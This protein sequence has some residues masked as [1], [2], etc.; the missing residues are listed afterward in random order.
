[1]RLSVSNLM[2]TAMWAYV[3]AH[4]AD[5]PARLFLHFLHVLLTFDGI[6]SGL[7]GLTFNKS[8]SCEGR[9]RTDFDAFLALAALLIH[10]LFR[11]LQ[12]GIG[13]NGGKTNPGACFS[14]DQKAALPYPSQAYQAGSNLMGK[15]RTDLLIVHSLGSEY[16][17][18]S[19]SRTFQAP[20]LG[21]G[22]WHPADH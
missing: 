2:L 3:K 17:I 13:E 19:V 8:P 16:R 1:M 22:R 12:R 20:C 15:S 6:V 10:E 4:A 11:G 18:G 7:P 14:S 21:E 5:R 9:C